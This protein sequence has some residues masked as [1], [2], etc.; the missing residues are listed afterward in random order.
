MATR[1]LATGVALLA[2]LAVGLY[3]LEILRA[4]APPEG[5]VSVPWDRAVCARCRMLV[6]DPSF[7][8]QLHTGSGDVLFF[9]D[10]GDLLLYLDDV[11]V[12]VRAV[13]LHHLEEDRWIPA[14]DAAFVPAEPTPM[15]Y[16]L[17]AV[18]VGEREDALSWEQA[19]ARVR[20]REEAR[21][22]A[23]DGG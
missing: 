20:D 3:I 16:G 23:G 5:P 9:D 12:D 11:D 1:S 4:Q 13:Y 21:R 2:T 15:G 14:S 8:A 22:R 6:S 7:A 19:L 17:G 10:P 18:E